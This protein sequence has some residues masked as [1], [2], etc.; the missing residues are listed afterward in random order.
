MITLK[1]VENI[2]IEEAK[3]LDL[4]IRHSGVGTINAGK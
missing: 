1:G 3:S 4:E 2:E